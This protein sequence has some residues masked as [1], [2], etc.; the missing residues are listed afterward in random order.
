MTITESFELTKN[1]IAKIR[2]E[3][4]RNKIAPGA[5]LFINTDK[6]IDKDELN[7]I[8][9]FD[10]TIRKICNLKDIIYF[11]MIDNEQVLFRKIQDYEK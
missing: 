1:F 4:T 2:K 5:T 6:F 11:C 10:V 7:S 3:K 8:F 9:H